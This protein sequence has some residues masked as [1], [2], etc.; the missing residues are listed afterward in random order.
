MNEAKIIKETHGGMEIYDIQDEMLTRR[1]IELVGT[2]DG[3]RVN[4]L[5]RQIRYLQH[6]DG[7]K[8]ITLFINSPGGE[9]ISGLALY[10]VMQACSCPIRTVCLGTAASM[11]ALLFCGGDSRDL[12]PHSKVLIHDPLINGSVEGNSTLQLQEIAENM[13]K[14]RDMT[15]TIMAKH[16]KRRKTEI[17]ELTKKDTVFFGQE[18]VEFGLADRVL[19]ALI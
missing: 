3:D 10:D 6:Q 18:A 8:E 5:I 19:T 4:T 2:V 15:A 14:L 7:E 12:F 17:L 13:L 11:G 1:E 16:C 9:V